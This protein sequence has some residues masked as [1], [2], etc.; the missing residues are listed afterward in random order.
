[1][2]YVSRSADILCQWLLYVLLLVF[3]GAVIELCLIPNRRRGNVLVQH[4]LSLTPFS[5]DTHNTELLGNP[6]CLLLFSCS[7]HSRMKF[8]IWCLYTNLTWLKLHRFWQTDSS[9]HGL[10][11]ISSYKFLAF[12]RSLI[13]GTSSVSGSY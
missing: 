9:V 12:K 1:M 10:C 4:L 8:S 5:S 11:F 13:L 2:V 3:V 6:C 7:L